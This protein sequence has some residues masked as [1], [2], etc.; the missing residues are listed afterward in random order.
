MKNLILVILVITLTENTIAQNFFGQNANQIVSGSKLVTKKE[1]KV[2]FFEFEQQKSIKGFSDSWLHNELTPNSKSDFELKKSFYDQLGN[3]HKRYIQTLNGVEIEHSEFYLHTKQG[4]LVS[5]NG[6]LIYEISPV[7]SVVISKEQAETV[8]SNKLNEEI[9]KDNSIEETKLILI[10]VDSAYLYTYKVDAYA[11]NAF[12]RNYYYVNAETSEIVRTESRIHETDVNGTVKTN[13]HGTQ[14]IK[15]NKSGSVYT[16]S[17]SDRGNGIN[18]YNANNYSSTYY[19]SLYSNSSSNWTNQSSMDGHDVHYGAEKSYDYFNQKFNLNSFDGNG[20]VIN[21]YSNYGRNVANAYWDGTNMIFGEGDGYSMTALTSTEIVA[22]EFTHAVTENSANLIYNGESGALNESFSDIFGVSV[23]FYANPSTANYLIG[24]E[25][26]LNGNGFRNMSNPNANGHPDTYHGSYWEYSSSDNYGVHTNSGVQNY[27]FY[28]VVNGGSGVNDNGDSYHVKAIGM[29]NAANIAFRNLTVY[30]TSTSDYEDARQFSIKSAEDLFGA[31]SDEV[32][33]VTNAWHAVGVGETFDGSI[34]ASFTSNI[35]QTCDLPKTILF[36][37]NSKNATS[38]NWDFGDGNTSILQNPAHTYTSIGDYDV[39]LIA[40]GSSECGSTPDTLLIEKYITITDNSAPKNTSCFPNGSTNPYY[41]I[42]SFTLNTINY[43]ENSLH[44]TIYKDLTCSQKTNLTEGVDYNFSISFPYNYYNHDVRIYLDKNNDGT[45]NSSTELI[46]SKDYVNYNL[47]D[48]INLPSGIIKNKPLRLRVAAGYYSYQH[49]PCSYSTNYETRDFTVEVVK[50]TMKPVGEFEASDSVVSINEGVTFTDLTTNLPTGWIWKFEG[51]NSPNQYT[52]NPTVYYSNA[53]SYDVKLIT[54]NN[55]GADTIL[56]SDYITVVNEYKMCDR[57]AANSSKKETGTIYD[58]GGENGYYSSYENCGFLINPECARN[59][60]L[61]FESFYTYTYD[62]LKVYDGPNNTYPELLNATGSFLPDDV[63]STQGSMYIEFISNGSY[64]G[65]GFKAYWEANVADSKPKANFTFQRDTVPL[66][67]SIKFTDLSENPFTWNWN[68]NGDT[69]TLQNPTTTFTTPGEKKI[70]LTVTNC[71][72]TDSIT[73]SLLV[74][75]GATV[76]WESDTIKFDAFCGDSTTSTFTVKNSGKGV[77][78]IKSDNDNQKEVLNILILNPQITLTNYINCKNALNEYSKSSTNIIESSPVSESELISL[79]EAYDID[80]IIFPPRTSGYSVGTTFSSA[81]VNFTNNGGSVLFTGNTSSRFRDEPFNSGLFN[82]FYNRYHTYPTLS[83][84]QPSS[85]LLNS[86]TNVSNMGNQWYITGSSITNTNYVSVLDITYNSSALGYRP[87]GKGKAYYF[88]H[89]FATENNNWKTIL[90]N[91]LENVHN[92]AKTDWFYTNNEDEYFVKPGDSIELSYGF[93]TQGLYADKYVT[94]WEITTNEGSNTIPVELNLKSNPQLTLPKT[95]VDFHSLFTGLSKSD[96]LKITNGSCEAILISNI[97]GAND[98]WSLDANSVIIPPYESRKI[99]ITFSPDSIGE[100]NT[101]LLFNYSGKTDTVCLTGKGIG[102][103]KLKLN[104]ES[105]TKKIN[106]CSDSLPYEFYIKNTGSGILNFNIND[107][108]SFYDSTS[109]ES[110]YYKGASTYHYFKPN[111]KKADSLI[112]NLKLSGDYDSYNEYATLYIDNQNLGQIYDTDYTNSYEVI[113]QK[114]VTGSQLENFLA[115]GQ[116]TVRI[117]NSSNVDIYFGSQTHEVSVNLVGIK[118]VSGKFSPDSGSIAISDS[119]KVTSWIDISKNSNGTYTKE[120]TISSNDPLNDSRKM[121]IVYTINGTA[122]AYMSSNLIEF[123]HAKPFSFDVATD[124]IVNEGCGPLKIT[125]VALNSTVFSID[126]I[127]SQ[128]NAFSNKSFAIYFTPSTGGTFQDT[129]FINTVDT[130]FQVVI[131]G[132]SDY[133]PIIKVNPSSLSLNIDGCDDSDSEYFTVKNAGAGVM[134]FEITSD[135]NEN[136]LD[137]IL[138]KFKANHTL[139]TN[140]IENLYPFTGGLSSYYIYD[141]GGDM[142][143]SGNRINTSNTLDI[144]YTNNNIYSSYSFGSGGKYFTSKQNGIF[145]LAADIN[146]ISQFSV[147][148]YLGA[149]GIGSVKS[150]SITYN[151]NGVNYKGFYYNTANTNVTGVNCLI[152]VEDYNSETSYVSSSTNYQDFR[153]MNL[154]NAKR[155]Y[156]LLFATSAYAN[157]PT[158]PVMKNVMSTFI[159]EVGGKPLKIEVTPQTGSLSA[160]E[161]TSIK[162]TFNN[163]WLDGG[164]YTE[165]IKIYST[166]L[167]NSPLTLPITVTISDKLCADMDYNIP[168]E[169]NGKVV[170]TDNSNNSPTSWKWNFG[171]GRTSSQENPTHTYTKN[172]T[173]SVSLESCNSNNCNTVS[174]KITIS[175][176]GGPKDA[177][178]TP[179]QTSNYSYGINRFILNTIDNASTNGI[180]GYEDFS[181]SHGTTLEYGKTYSATVLFESSSFYDNYATLWI[182]KNGD[183]NFTHDEEIDSQSDSYSAVFNFTIDETYKVD[184]PLRLRVGTDL[185]SYMDSECSTYYGEIEDYSITVYNSNFT[186]NVAQNEFTLYPNPTNKGVKVRIP[187]SS[188]INSLQVIN[189]TGQIIYSIKTN[190][191]V[192]EDIILV[193]TQSLPP[194]TYLVKSITE[195]GLTFNQAFVVTK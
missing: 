184:N 51:A 36:T 103:P 30:L 109:I 34:S 21:S 45:F 48:V 37:S 121:P 50:N 38:F 164:K 131:K 12:V 85:E 82:G 107:Y 87:I 192:N 98:Y 173:Y 74:D 35:T 93:A 1:G 75:S 96:S 141:G 187:E 130:T 67:Y 174:E 9:R 150:G 104:P 153:V 129:L 186:N 119:I 142:Y 161:S 52:Q 136:S 58:S 133:P 176:V 185:L 63:V 134:N 135:S 99:E 114:I 46:Y 95:C 143:D 88:G 101:Q 53:G 22:H 182:D 60:T 59:I 4:N 84:N 2:N 144:N 71:Y 91:I 54:V 127:G 122:N 17:E 72:G 195:N 169:C 44:D 156:Y 168:G 137:S 172:G 14:N 92:S 80:L 33:A 125:S 3:L 149:D 152:I 163:N 178:C 179:V 146:N 16:L 138:S 139:I 66:N 47:N 23:D 90:S 181:C 100:F 31:C 128:V 117:A 89:N 123:Q 167:T 155:I 55:N 20:H 81:L 26:D 115:D 42:S 76:I 193:F 7:N 79:I 165:N 147:K 64:Q 188:K 73:K 124:N 126:S 56:K 69:S 39:T 154:D 41:G 86:I 106:L 10:K 24:D 94:N 157:A 160:G 13:Y 18:S 11:I 62:Y 97:S 190:N 140:E 158:E 148:G 175:H 162:Y 83:T 6:N 108:S 177:S 43:K 49:L 70:T 166:D 110:Y 194:G 171:D 102:T 5:G 68:I 113:S 116:I 189:S 118:G 8:A 61:S 183:G 29:D 112:I 180:S 77:L 40:N 57:N 65:D 170:F 105:I 151:K 120:V 111:I 78:S 159:D 32:E 25:S 15:C 27:W 191:T 132:S 145:L 28:L 19:G